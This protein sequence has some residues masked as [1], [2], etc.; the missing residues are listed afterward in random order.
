QMLCVTCNNTASNTMMV[1]NLAEALPSFPGRA[2]HTRCFLHTI[3][4]VAKSL[5]K[6]FD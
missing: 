4:L 2:I 6:E 1:E 5:L 3:N